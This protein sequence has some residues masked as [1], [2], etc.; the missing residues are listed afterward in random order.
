MH[1]YQSLSGERNFLS[2]V[3][4]KQWKGE[5]HS[6][7]NRTINIIS[8]SGELYT[9]AAAELDNV[10]NTL[11]V[12]SFFN[13]PPHLTVETSVFIKEGQL[14]I[15]KVARIEL[16]NVNEWQYP[17]IEFP[18]KQEYSRLNERVLL[19]NKWLEEINDASGYLLNP[20]GTAYEKM[21]Y[22]MLWNESNQL[23]M[24]LKEKQL[25]QAMKQLNRL[26]GLGPGLTPSGDDFL[27]GLALIF[28]TTNYPYHSLQQWLINSRYTLKKRTNI[29][30]FSTLDWAIKGVARE[31]IGLFLE[32]LFYGE[33]QDVLK[34]K[35]AA[36]LLIGATSGGDMLSGMLAGIKLTL[37]LQGTFK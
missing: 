35:M 4:N 15:D 34:E 27:V 8:N 28:T 17:N 37:D 12:S 5:V 9:I 14:V 22:S 1:T 36:V 2:I 26:I 33:R 3:Q 32:E 20:K 21:I 13:D 11:R 31:R 10:P 16:K 24:Y 30:S 23:L 25:F 29:I 7:F 19:V 18:K 6:I